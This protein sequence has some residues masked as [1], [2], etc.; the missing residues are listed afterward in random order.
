MINPSNPLE[1]CFLLELSPLQSS[2]TYCHL[3]S[4]MKLCR[5]SSSCMC[6]LV[7]VLDATGSMGPWIRSAESKINDI[8][9]Y[10]QRSK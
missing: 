7:F 1:V 4:T 10:T 9:M 5:T 3:E 8:V 2:A 6:D